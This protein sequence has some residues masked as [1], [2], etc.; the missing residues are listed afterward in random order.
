MIGAVCGWFAVRCVAMCRQ[1][2]N[3]EYFVLKYRPCFVPYFLSR[4][5]KALLVLSKNEVRDMF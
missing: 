5:Q 2:E 1:L 4:N 3:Q